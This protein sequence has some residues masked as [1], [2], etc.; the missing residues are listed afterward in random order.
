MFTRFSRFYDLI[1]SW[2]NYRQEV[3]ICWASSTL[4]RPE[5]LMPEE[6]KMRVIYLRIVASLPSEKKQQSSI[7]VAGRPSICAKQ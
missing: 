5:Q 7:Q 3:D 4:T 2:K 1:Y 6:E